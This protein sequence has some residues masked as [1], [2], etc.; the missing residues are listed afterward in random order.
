[1]I[2]DYHSKYLATDLVRRRSSDSN[3]KLSGIQDGFARV[4]DARHTLVHGFTSEAGLQPS[5]INLRNDHQ[6][7]MRDLPDLVPWADYICRLAI[8][9]YN[10]STRGIYSAE[11]DMPPLSPIIAPPEKSY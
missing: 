1:M 3:E 9:A 11:Q 6:V 5:A 4:R 10:D 2:T 7:W 8:Q